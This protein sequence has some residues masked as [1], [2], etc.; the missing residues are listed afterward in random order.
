MRFIH[1]NHLLSIGDT[2]CYAGIEGYPLWLN[3][4]YIN[5]TG[6]AGSSSAPIS[7]E[8]GD[9]ISLSYKINLDPYVNDTS[10]PENNEEEN[11]GDEITNFN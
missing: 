3:Q 6:S 10:L 9:T 2:Y 1:Q 5:L 7:L 11:N 4:T 8:G